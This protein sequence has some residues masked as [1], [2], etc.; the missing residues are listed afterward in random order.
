VSFCWYF[1]V[2]FLPK[3]LEEQ[4]H[5]SFKESRWFSGSP[6]L[7]GAAGCLIGGWASDYLIRRTGSRRW[8]RSLFGLFGFGLA[9]VFTLFIPSLPNYIWVIVALCLVSVVQDMAIPCIWAVC[10]DIGERFA[11][12]V[13]GCM[14]SVGAVG[15]ILGI[16]L[17]PRLARDFGWNRVFIVNGCLYLAGALLWLRINATERLVPSSALPS[18][19]SGSRLNDEVT[20]SPIE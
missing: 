20:P 19:D 1:N 12:T 5:V 14:N 3:Y 11:A 9:G 6:L 8:G 16:L 15:S 2:T 18:E 13:A 10:A 7:V 4:F 17:A